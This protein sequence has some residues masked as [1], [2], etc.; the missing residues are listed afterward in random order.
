MIYKIIALNIHQ[1]PNLN[2]EE[3]PDNIQTNKHSAVK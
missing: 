1:I 3:N 2:L